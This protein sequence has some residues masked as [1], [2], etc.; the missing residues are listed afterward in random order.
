MKAGGQTG[1]HMRVL[2]HG[3]G[4]TRTLVRVGERRVKVVSDLG[5]AVRRVLT[6]LL[7][8]KEDANAPFLHGE[9]GYRRLLIAARRV[10]GSVFRFASWADVIPTRRRS[11]RGWRRL[12]ALRVRMEGMDDVHVVLLRHEL[13]LALHG[14]GGSAAF[15]SRSDGR[16]AGVAVAH[17]DN[18]SY[19]DFSLHL[20]G[21]SLSR[22]GGNSLE[23]DQSGCLRSRPQGCGWVKERRRVGGNWAER[24]LQ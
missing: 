12:G 23:M 7:V 2:A 8:K 11:R 24:R 22:A 20:G 4:Q 5:E 21:G 13:D 17:G 6:A 1:Q 19:L 3:G 9:F 16:D 15:R 18:V 14:E 10:V